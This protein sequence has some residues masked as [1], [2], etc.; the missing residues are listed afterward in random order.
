MTIAT[1]N[2]PLAWPKTGEDLQ[3][4]AYW[5]SRS[6]GLLYREVRLGG[7]CWPDPPW[8]A[9]AS[10]RRLD[11]VIVDGEPSGPHNHGRFVF[12]LPTLAGR[13]CEIIEV[14][15]GL[16]EFVLGQALVGRWLFQQQV[17]TPNSLEIRRNLVLARHVDP[18]MRWVATQ[19][20][21]DVETPRP[22]AKP[23]GTKS[24]PRYMLRDA[25]LAR[26][27]R[28][29]TQPQAGATQ[30][31][32][33]LTRVPLAG[34]SC[35]VQEW[36]GAAQTW[37][38]FVHVPSQP[39]GAGVVVYGPQ[40]RELLSEARELELVFVGRH[41]LGRGAVGIVAAHAVM[42]AKQYGRAFTRCRIISGT[43]DPAIVA[44][45]GSLTHGL[46]IPS[47]EI[48]GVGDVGAEDPDLSDEE[49]EEGGPDA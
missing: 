40:H 34:P 12:D 9:P 45:C 10:E 36:E 28:W 21:I 25:K 49:N 14:K 1:P 39:A 11:G 6:S 8:R 44:A 4:D 38:D 30:P 42:F 27:L 19:L 41:V 29:R 18:A 31:G 17:A 2:K 32:L 23:S 33:I 5:R 46:P 7:A 35:D 37:I 16:S 26:L 20:G 24:R 22:A 3:L 15:A 43:P 13:A 47:I 48:I